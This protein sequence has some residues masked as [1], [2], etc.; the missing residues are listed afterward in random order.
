M[1]AERENAAKVK[2][3]VEL[4]QHSIRIIHIMESAMQKHHIDATI[5]RAD[6][7]IRSDSLDT[8][9]NRSGRYADTRT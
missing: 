7:L 3:P 4:A 2:D 6:P 5:G 1:T 8:L 9:P